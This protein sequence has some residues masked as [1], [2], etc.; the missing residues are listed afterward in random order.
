MLQAIATLLT[1]ELIGLAAFP[2]VAR[3]FPLLADRGWAISKPVGMLLVAT[4]VW[5][6]SYTRLVPNT[7]LTWWVF[8]I[9]LGFGSSLVLGSDWKRLR[10][11]LVRRWRTIVTIELIFLAFFLMFLSMRA[12][13]PA[14]AG[15]EKPMDLMMLTAVTSAEYAPP[16]DLWLAGEPIAYYYFGYWIYGGVN[17]MAGTGPAVAYNVGLALVAG[18]AASVVAALVTTL[19]RRDGASTKVALLAGGVS[20]FLLL[21]VSNLSGLWTLL[22][23]TRIAPDWLLNWY[24]G[25][26]YPRVDRIATWRPDD[27]GWWWESSRIISTFGESGND[28]DFTI[29][30]YPFFSFLL[31]DFH[32][33]LM[34]IPFL[35]TGITVLT[36]L[37]IAYRTIS[38]GVLRRNVPAA[39]IAAVVIGSSGF[40]NFWDVGLLLMLSTGLVIA[41][42]VLTRGPG[43][44][45]L[46]KAALPLGVLWLV[47]MLI[48]SPFYF[49][50]AESQVQSPAI[51]PVR[52]GSRPIHFVSVWLLLMIVV[53]PIAIALAKKYATAVFDRLRGQQKVSQSDRQLIWRPAWITGLVLVVLPWLVWVTTHL[54]FNDNARASDVISRLPVTG[55]LGVISVVLIAVTLGRAHRG[56]DEG[57]HYVLLLGALALYLLFAAELFFVHDLFG[58]RMNTVFKFYYQAWILLSAVGG[59]GAY[60]WWRHHPALTGRTVWIS[61]TGIAV[62]AVVVVS[63][64]YF[65]VASAVTK[66]VDSGLGPNLDSLSFLEAWD[67]EELDVIERIREIADS[68]DHLIEA[69]GES[70]SDYGR[71]AGLSGVPTVIGWAFHEKQW[72]GSDRAFAH[73]RGDVETIYTTDDEQELR[74]LIDK[75]SLTMVV[76]GPRE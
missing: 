15:T 31:G 7:P 66:T 71:I 2:I 56:A 51:L 13:D 61:R 8:L 55:L 63:S 38:F 23:I 43:L 49:G 20:S 54:A 32:P 65:P 34:S 75:Y 28:L 74:E 42:W 44:K 16:E 67:Q 27:F 3:A 9:V 33:H 57:A 24:Q 76:V 11:T 62:L 40:I 50:T 6:A 69:A 47:G 73:R 5:L 64:V 18:M 17:A 58:N 70:Y 4:A 14:A 59:Y 53:A 72:H 19:V 68:N 39:L 26:N 10:K 48:Y 12:F 45:S 29:Q 21:L 30:E 37:F 22:D 41:G 1:V 35:L 46:I 60:T 36:A 25:D 52:Y